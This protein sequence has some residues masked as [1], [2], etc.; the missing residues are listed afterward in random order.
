MEFHGSGGIVPWSP[1]CTILLTQSSVFILLT[2]SHS[3]PLSIKNMTS[4][5]C[6]SGIELEGHINFIL[7]AVVWGVMYRLGC[8][9]VVLVE[10]WFVNCFWVSG[11]AGQFV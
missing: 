6:N 9:Q 1:I 10:L 11:L 3:I 7:Y 8:C 4:P 2:L 5:R